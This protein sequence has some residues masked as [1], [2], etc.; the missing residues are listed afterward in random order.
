MTAPMPDDPV[1]REIVARLVSAVDPER[2]ILFGSRARGT[3]GQH[4][5]SQA[6]RAGLAVY[7]KAL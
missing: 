2:L 7:E 1:P 5:I 4:V 3:G 6:V